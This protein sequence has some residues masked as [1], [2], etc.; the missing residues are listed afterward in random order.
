MAGHHFCHYL[1]LLIHTDRAA[2]QLQSFDYWI[3]HRVG[4]RHT[5]A[6]A[7]SHHPVLW[8]TVSS[9]RLGSSSWS[10]QIKEGPTCEGWAATATCSELTTVTVA[11]W[12]HGQEED[13]DLLPVL[14]WLEAHQQPTREE[15]ALQS[16]GD[17]AG[18]RQAVAG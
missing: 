9:G 11:E 17:R 1:L 6:D 15:I 4:E 10:R 13:S 14:E 5:N 12:R 3:Q 7:L 18:V 16:G 2:L 8:R